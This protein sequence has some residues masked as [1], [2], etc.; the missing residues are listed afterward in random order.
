MKIKIRTRIGET[1]LVDV[2]STDDI[3]M[4]KDKICTIKRF[5]VSYQALFYGKNNLKDAT[6]LNDAYITHM[7]TVYL[8]IRNI[9]D[10]KTSV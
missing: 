2:K 7:S 4:V 6:I 5:P 8:V 1:F 9:V 3:L 10:T